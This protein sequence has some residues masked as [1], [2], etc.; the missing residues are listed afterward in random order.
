MPTAVERGS[1]DNNAKFTAGNA[2]GENV[3]TTPNENADNQFAT[4]ENAANGQP[5]NFGLLLPAVRNPSVG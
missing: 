2:N 3:E 4:N 5:I 1:S